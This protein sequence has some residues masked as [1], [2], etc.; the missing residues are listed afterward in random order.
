MKKLLIILA[1][2][3]AM[4]AEAQMQ[5]PQ[6][7]PWSSFCDSTMKILKLPRHYCMCKE[8]SDTF[9]FPLETVITDTVWYTATLNDLRQGF[10]A[11]WF[12]NTSV[13]ME[14]FAFCASKGPTFSLTVGPNQMRE[15]DAKMIEDKLNDLSKEQQLMV[16]TLTPHMR[17]YPHNGDTGRVYC[18]P[19]NHG[20]ESK[21]D[22]PLPLRPG[23]TYIC[24]KEENVYRL[25][26]SSIAA[27]GKAFVL[28]KQQKNK[29]CEIWLTLDSCTGKEIGRAE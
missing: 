26:W 7:R 21:C 11:Y 14:V 9:A 16:E 27:S 23:M 13:T 15:V 28:W 8:F 24:E 10:C 12:S 1:L 29:P 18:Y 17:V 25:E 4:K 22:N 5:M 3:A 2:V 19:Y 6:A 20:P